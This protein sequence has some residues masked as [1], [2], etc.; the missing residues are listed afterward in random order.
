M[1]VIE[2]GGPD[3]E[4]KESDKIHS[5]LYQIIIGVPRFA[6]NNLAELELGRNSSEHDFKILVMF[7]M[8]GLSGNGKIML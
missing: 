6:A 5:W 7:I 4:W 3:G 1:Y 8:H 2:K